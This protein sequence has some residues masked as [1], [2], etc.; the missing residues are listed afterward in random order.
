M[1]SLRFPAFILSLAL[2]ALA[3]P[4]PSE[5]SPG[6]VFKAGSSIT[7]TWTPDTVAGGPWKT[8][9]IELMTGDNFH[10]VHLTSQCRL[11][12]VIIA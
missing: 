4:T 7:A 3:D 5:P 10:M 1:F 6:D 9:N 11:S 2:A 12:R 8:M